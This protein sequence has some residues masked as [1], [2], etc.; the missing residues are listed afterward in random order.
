VGKFFTYQFFFVSDFDKKELLK[1]NFFWRENL[2]VL[3]SCEKIHALFSSKTNYKKM[4]FGYT[5]AQTTEF[6]KNGEK[7]PVTLYDLE[8]YGLA[9]MVSRNRE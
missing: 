3:L 6:W 7:L 8:K 2:Q 9:P 4:C 5:I 1:N